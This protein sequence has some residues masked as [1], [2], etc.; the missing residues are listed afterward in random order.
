[1]EARSVSLEPYTKARAVLYYLRLIE[2]HSI[3]LRGNEPISEFLSGGYSVCNTVVCLLGLD[4]LLERID[5][6]HLAAYLISAFLAQNSIEH[7]IVGFELKYGGT[8]AEHQLLLLNGLK[9][10]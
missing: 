3:D 7:I 1:M 6:L 10:G 2:L 5:Q 9:V 8:A 4:E